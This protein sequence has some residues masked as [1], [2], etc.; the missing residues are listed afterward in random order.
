MNGWGNGPYARGRRRVTEEFRASDTLLPGRREAHDPTETANTMPRNWRSIGPGIRDDQA[1]PAAPDSRTGSTFN[2][3]KA[4]RH[5]V[6][7]F[8]SNSSDS[9]AGPDNQAFS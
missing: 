1:C 8:E 7:W 9:S 5:L 3:A 6:S 2:F 4:R